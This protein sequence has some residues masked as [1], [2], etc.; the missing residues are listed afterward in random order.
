[1]SHRIL[2]L[3]T[4]VLY[5]TLMPAKDGPLSKIFGGL[6]EYRIG[7]AIA[8]FDP[9]SWTH[10]KGA[11]PDI[12]QL[13]SPPQPFTAANITKAL[14]VFDEQLKLFAIESY[15]PEASHDQLLEELTQTLGKPSIREIKFGKVYFWKRGDIEVS[16]GPPRDGEVD[17]S[18]VSLE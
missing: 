18:W 3:L 2:C 17:V 4:I 9:S 16:I 5:A 12:Y 14:L 1:M 8:D 6:G 15:L 10:F 7:R 13:K 11:L